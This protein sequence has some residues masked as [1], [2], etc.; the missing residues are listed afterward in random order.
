MDTLAT[1][2][3]QLAETLDSAP[4]PCFVNANDPP[5]F[6][7]L[8]NPASFLWRDLLRKLRSA[9][10]IPSFAEVSPA[11]W[12]AKLR[13]SMV[14]GQEERNPAVKLLAFYEQ[15][16]ESGLKHGGARPRRGSEVDRAAGKPS[17]VV[18]DTTASQRDCPVLRNPPKMLEG[19]YI[20]KFLERWMESWQIK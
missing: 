18:F 1:A 17:A 2:I 13:A 16:Y 20:D 12:L 10:G 5:V 6:Y 15:Q 9:P 8:V 19:G 7:N 14:L 4:R 11:L 3:L